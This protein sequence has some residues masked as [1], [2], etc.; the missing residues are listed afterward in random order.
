MHHYINVNYVNFHLLHCNDI[1]GQF[2]QNTQIC[3]VF[4]H[5]FYHFFMSNIH[6]LS[7]KM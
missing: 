2:V 6:G 5:Y 4:V 3:F 7:H 1:I